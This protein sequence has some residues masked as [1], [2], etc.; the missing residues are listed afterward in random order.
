MRFGIGSLAGANIQNAQLFERLNDAHQRYRELFETSTD[1]ILI[2][3]WKGNILE[4]N[5]QAVINSEYPELE[6]HGLNIE[7][8]H[9][10][11]WEKTGRSFEELKTYGASSYE[12]QLHQKNGQSLPVQVEVRSV[13]FEETDVLGVSLHQCCKLGRDARDCVASGRSAVKVEKI[14]NAVKL[15]S[16]FGAACPH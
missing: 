1:S 16:L 12:S 14:A 2:T 7:S 11:N 5:R 9:D 3:D 13:D 6:L 8:L 15:V 10:V 4:A